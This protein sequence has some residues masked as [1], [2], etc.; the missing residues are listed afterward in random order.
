MRLVSV[1]VEG[2]GKFRS[3]VHISNMAPG[4]NVL[5]AENEAG[6][7]TIFRA[8]RTCIFDRHSSTKK[9]IEELAT[10]DA[11]LP[12]AVTVEF[13]QAGHIYEI[14][15]SFLRSTSARLSRDKIE[16]ARGAQADEQVWELLGVAQGGGKSVDEAVFG[17]LW[18]GQAQSFTLPEP[19]EAATS[20]MNAA[21]QAEVGT[22]VGGER[23]RRALGSVKDELDKLVTEKR[24][25][26]KHG[27]LFKAEQEEQRLASAL[28]EAEAALA[29]LD[30]KIE[31]LGTKRA[32]RKRLS[33]PQE[34]QRIAEELE[35]AKALLKSG[36]ETRSRL[37][38]HESEEQLALSLLQA[39]KTSLLELEE[40][41]H[42]IDDR[43]KQ[44][45]LL[46]ESLAGLEAKEKSVSARIAS[47]IDDQQQASR[48]LAEIEAREIVL[49]KAESALAAR[50]S[51]DE[52]QKRLALFTDLEQR[53]LANN[54]SL[55]ANKATAKAI[56]ALD[57]IER[58]FEKLNA[59]LEASAAQ[60][61]IDL[62]DQK[63]NA[64][65]NG[66]KIG[67]SAAR[68]VIDPLNLEFPGIAS[69]KI[70]PPATTLATA[71]SKR[72]ELTQTLRQLLNACGVANAPALRAAFTARQTLESQ[73]KQLDA[74][75][76]GLGIKEQTL[77]LAIE[78]T[79]SE[80]AR[81]DDQLKSVL[82]AIEGVFTQDLA[83]AELERLAQARSTIGQRRLEIESSLGA[84]NEQSGKLA[85]EIGEKRGS[86]QALLG[87][88][89]TDQAALP[90]DKRDTLLQEAK[91]Q[92]EEKQQS[93]RAKAAFLEAQ[94]K[95]APT[96]DEL[97]SLR[98]RVD[99]YQS[100]LAN[101]REAL[102]QLDT[103]IAN[104]EGRIQEA[105]GDG[106]GEKTAALREEV[107]LAKRELQRQQAHVATLT[108][109]RDVIEQSYHERREQ[110]N[111]PLRRYLRPFL[112]DLF[113]R[114]EV[115]LGEG[116][117]I[118]NIT[119]HGP[120][121]EHFERLSDGTQEQIAVLVRLAMGAMLADQGREVP[122][123][124]DDA[125]VFSDDARIEQMFDALNRAGQKQQVIVL[126]CRAKA[127]SL[128]GGRQL[129][130]T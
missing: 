4:V 107:D 105:G 129:S 130:I 125:L 73:S 75:K 6:K 46:E 28:R 51:K 89:K 60:V 76:L 32:D 66:E 112:N 17:I 7:S 78:R 63:I 21:I 19:S 93:H 108:L 25:A 126:T 102:A 119:R 68:S 70:S 124:L 103:L 80:L 59:R 24:Q 53:T 104:L 14:K 10:K 57:E 27:D 22:L 109:L 120:G 67:G 123:I 86:L 31:T 36:E 18:V 23:A 69:V 97:D 92:C 84:A 127:F 45:A 87:Q 65:L 12:L 61:S 50:S 64:T 15:K 99:R 122:V 34:A 37:K 26:R 41:A 91:A 88:L 40:R 55:A 85:K 11:A 113:P 72:D 115:D 110:L 71:A 94:R 2:V 98:N 39:A 81:L 5:M 56:A 128:L 101:R 90:D 58:E 33:D 35:K 47:L 44:A 29:E 114:A 20:A 77:G 83:S 74:E 43:R 82:A 13:E 49:R 62:I 1:S 38:Q 100:S 121:P 111:A 116:F 8:I 96:E 3:P 9:S 30:D 117:V 95:Q 52:L 106:L 16:I 42:R 79:K 118:E 54:T 48:K